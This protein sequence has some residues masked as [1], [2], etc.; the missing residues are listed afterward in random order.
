MTEARDCALVMMENAGYIHGELAR[1]EMD[2]ELRE[3][4]VRLCEDLVGTEH[5]VI[6]E[7]FALDEL[8][9]RAGG[10]APPVVER[11]ERIIGWLSEDV[12][13]VHELV[14]GLRS[15]TDRDPEYA[16][17][18]VLVMESAVNI[19]DAYNRTVQAADSLRQE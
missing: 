13:M 7:L 18:Y 8:L 15:S 3:R 14:L 17:G 11:I 10:S 16:L 19:L 1:V 2:G 9:E 4:T 6:S 12:G 5:D